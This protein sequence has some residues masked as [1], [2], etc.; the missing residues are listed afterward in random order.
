MDMR[1]RRTAPLAVAAATVMLTANVAVAAPATFFEMPFPCGQTWTGTTYASHSPNSNS[2][3]WNRPDDVD[4]AVVAAAPGTVSLA[5]T[6]DNG[7][8]GKYVI[9]DHPNGDKSLYAHLNRVL[10][11]VGQRVDQGQQI[12]NVGSTGSSTGP[13]LHFE[14]RVSGTTVAAYFHGT[15]YVM[16]T[17]QASTNC[18]DVPLA[19]D[20]NGDKIAQPTVFRRGSPSSFQVYREGATPQVVK[21][22]GPTDEP[23][24]GDWDGNGSINPGVR[25]P[26]TRTF[27]MRSPLGTTA[28]AFGLV[29]DRPVAGNWT[30]DAV[31]EIGV[32]RASTAQFLLRSPTGVVTKIGLGDANDLPV[33]GDWDADGFTDLGT[34]DQATSTFL[35]R[36][37]DA[38][39]TVW[40]AKV[41][42]GTPGDLPVTGDW[43][44]NGRTDLGTWTP[45]TATFNRR[46]ATA[47]TTTARAT[48]TLQF[49]RHR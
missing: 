23:V 15:K 13:H 4:D 2:I 33:T 16:G 8:Y 44:G 22:G 31:W 38:E 3:D 10:V 1:A 32:W 37:V 39:G 28:L 29:S 49:G 18:V 19:P 36:R 6:V 26:E 17:A 9:V 5:Q 46:I 27:T 11:T 14:E 20:W 30:G 34:Y 45:S 42:Y 25:T 21:F 7:G 41:A 47:P 24:P 40:T 12:G 48:T 35:L 43:D